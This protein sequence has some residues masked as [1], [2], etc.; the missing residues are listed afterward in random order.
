MSQNRWERDLSPVLSDL[1]V[2]WRGGSGS[3]TLA[4]TL[5]FQTN[6]EEGVSLP[7]C[8]KGKVAGLQ[9]PAGRN[10]RLRY[11]TALAAFPE[12]DLSFASQLK[13][14]VHRCW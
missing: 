14:K 8:W 12:R 10:Q 7:S 11:L 4:L 9:Q 5:V 13:A 3:D 1:G 2:L 6:L